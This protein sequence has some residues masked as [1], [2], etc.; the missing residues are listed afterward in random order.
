METVLVLLYFACLLPESLS[1]WPCPK[2]RVGKNH[3]FVRL[4]FMFPQTEKLITCLLIKED[5]CSQYIRQS[6]KEPNL[7]YNTLKHFH[8]MSLIAQ[9]KMSKYFFSHFILSCYEMSCA[10]LSATHNKCYLTRLKHR[11][12]GSLSVYKT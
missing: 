2:F 8:Q 11:K 9:L 4:Q 6:K 3:S 12:C 7:C 10:V 5:I 1:V